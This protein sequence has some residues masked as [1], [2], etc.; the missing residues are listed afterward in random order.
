MTTL[1]T[2]ARER[3][4]KK[5]ISRKRA[6]IKAGVETVGA[7]DD[8][9][10]R[11]I[12]ARDAA[13]LMAVAAKYQAANCPNRANQIRNEAMYLQPFSIDGTPTPV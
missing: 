6:A 9:Y 10:K 8:E 2:S 12:G 13:A 11:A 4:I 5:V 1:Y 7:L 3:E